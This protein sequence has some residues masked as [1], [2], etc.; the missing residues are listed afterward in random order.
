[1]AKVRGKLPE[2]LDGFVV[3]N[4]PVGDRNRSEARLNLNKLAIEFGVLRRPLREESVHS[5]SEPPRI[6]FYFSLAGLF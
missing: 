2:I 4:R 1:M 5:I 6:Y 3:K